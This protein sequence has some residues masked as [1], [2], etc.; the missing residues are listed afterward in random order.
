MRSFA[1]GITGASIF[2]FGARELMD[3]ADGMILTRSRIQAF[4]GDIDKTNFVL[5]ELVKQANETKSSI[6]DTKEVFSRILTSTS[7]LNI[8]LESQIALSRILQQSFRLSGSTAAEATASTIQ[9]SQA[10]SF[11]QL[12]GQ[13]LRSVLSQNS[14][15][16]N[17]F[18]KAIEGSG[19][20]IYKFAEAG[21]FTT[22]FVLKVLSEQFNN[23]EKQA[24]GLSQTFGQTLTLAMNQFQNKVAELNDEFDLNGKFAVGVQTLIDNLETLGK[25]ALVLASATLPL[26]IAKIVALV[27]ALNPVTLVIMGIT[28]ATILVIDNWDKLVVSAKEIGLVAT[29]VFADMADKIANV[30]ISIFRAFGIDAPKA[31]GLFK[32]ST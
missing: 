5:K 6:N 1:A 24:N 31:L 26:L 25:V 7:R 29:I 14:V 23:I 3:L 18:G 12:R 16:A 2:G 15:L 13:E 32:Q 30:G 19:K 21:G 4:T 17:I 27:T 11:G 28:A 20:D 9:F 22:K 8:S 10:L